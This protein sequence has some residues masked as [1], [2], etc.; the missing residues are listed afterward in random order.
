MSAWSK[1]L[2]F[3]LILGLV[4]WGLSFWQKPDSRLHLVFF[5]VGQ[6]DALFIKSP[7]G[8]NILIDG[9]PDK[10]VLYG[11]GEK[12][13]F[14]QRNL[15][16]VILTHPH[17]DHLIGL[18]EVLK[19][20]QV[21]K[22]ASSGVVH[23]S[24]EYLK[25]LELIKEKN[26]PFQPLHLGDRF[27]FEDGL[28]LE[29]LWPFEVLA[30]K[31][32][33]DLNESS[34]VLRLSYGD[35]SALLTGDISKTTEEK[36]MNNFNFQVNVLKVPHHGSK[37]SLDEE[38]LKMLACQTAV[39]CVGQNKFGHPAKETLEKLKSLRVLR[40]DQEGEIEI[41]SDGKDYFI[42]TQKPH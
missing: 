14:W 30:G 39:I 17:A 1:Y 9:G 2:L 8:K 18:I 38:F 10:S 7:S 37:I 29:V 21:K 6:G 13:P 26:I 22:V 33:E 4:L 12:L 35:F 40:T 3:I 36:L 41:I 23:T 42:Q 19:N 5:D 31:Q 32:V 24:S 25:F 34:V 11:L 27:D 20:Y 28:S 15:D 16:L